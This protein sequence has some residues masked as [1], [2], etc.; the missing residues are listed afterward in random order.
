ML[1]EFITDACEVFERV[2]VAARRRT[3]EAKADIRFIQ[4]C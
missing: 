3:H 2:S 4:I 1:C